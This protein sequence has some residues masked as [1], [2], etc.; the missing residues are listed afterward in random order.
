MQTPTPTVITALLLELAPVVAFA[1]AGDRIA[2]SVRRWP[3]VARIF[4]PA[5]CVLPYVAVSVSRQMF[6][7][8]WFTLY[9]ALP[10]AIAWLLEQ[11]VASDPEQRGNWQ[12]A[13]I[14]LTF[15]LAVDLRWFDAAW[16][17]GLRV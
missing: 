2:R 10:V 11:A 15:G 13:I 12:D 4:F 16:P 5:L 7:W 6:R 14:L 9:A 17:A 1:V 8:P 3:T